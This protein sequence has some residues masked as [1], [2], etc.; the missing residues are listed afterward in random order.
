[1]VYIVGGN[2]LQISGHR[3]NIVIQT[4]RNVHV[5]LLLADPINFH[6]VIVLFKCL[7]ENIMLCVSLI[8]REEKEID[9]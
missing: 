7:F 2:W 9:R 8:L 4:T 5:E 6:F 1:M 3:S